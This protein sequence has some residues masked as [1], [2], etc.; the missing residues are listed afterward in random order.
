MPM[1]WRRFIVAVVCGSL[2]L[3]AAATVLLVI[4]TSV[5]G[6][7]SHAADA[8][9]LFITGIVILAAGS[10]V[11][12]LGELQCRQCNYILRGISE[13]RCRECGAGI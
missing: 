12:A 10:T 1:P 3:A 13:P 11:A 9:L 6:Y 5:L 8:A 7:A 4:T 2:A